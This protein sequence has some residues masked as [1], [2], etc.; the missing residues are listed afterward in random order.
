MNALFAMAMG[1]AVLSGNEPE[2]SAELGF[3]SPVINIL[4]DATF[5]EN[6][7]ESLVLD[8][9]RI[10]FH[11]MAGRECVIKYHDAGVVAS[12]YLS[13]LTGKTSRE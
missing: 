10:T 2:C 4:P 7:L 12:Q 11:G 13:L 3:Q 1:K 5:I 6:T 9:S 8:P